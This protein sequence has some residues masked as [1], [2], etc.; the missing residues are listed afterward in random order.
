M[1]KDVKGITWVGNIYQKF[2][3]MCLEVEDIIVEDAA[4]YVEHQMQTVG[5]S[6]KKLYSDVMQDLLP[7]SCDLD[8]KIASGLPIH[9]NTDAGFR[10]K[11][12]QGSEKITVKDDIKQ[13]NEDSRINH[14]TDDNVTCAA[15]CDTDA[16]FMPSSGNSIKGNDCIS[17]ARQF[18]GS[19]DVTSNPGSDESQQNKEMLASSTVGEVTLL[20]TDTCRTSQSCELSNE[21]ENHAVTISKLDY[22]EVTRLASV[23]GRCNEIEIASDEQIPNV[24]ILVKSAE[25]KEMNTSSSSSVLFGDPEGKYLV[26]GI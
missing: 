4:K 21:I 14:D 2:E 6:F 19:T 25:E 1:A 13:T 7:T 23:A 10:K 20:E 3:N 12:L 11:K 9:Q 22:T 24:L 18:V 5:E 8:E 16:V 17:R 15:S 26:S